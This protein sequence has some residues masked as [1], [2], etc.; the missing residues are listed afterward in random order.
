MAD[1]AA[2]AGLPHHFLQHRHQL[3]LRRDPRHA[4]RCLLAS[5]VLGLLVDPYS[6]MVRIQMERRKWMPSLQMIKYGTNGTYAE[7][8]L[9]H[10]SATMNE[11][12]VDLLLHL[13][14]NNNV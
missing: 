12:Y 11:T 3:P 2:L 5:V 9:D 8:R 13:E 4:G 6:T 10:G 14:P 1:S 7:P